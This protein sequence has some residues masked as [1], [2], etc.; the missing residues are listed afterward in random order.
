MSAD[1]DAF[2]RWEA[3]QKLAAEIL[4]EGGK[5]D[6]DYLAALEAV[7]AK[8]NDDPAFAAQMVMP[9]AENEIAAMRMPA[10]PDAIHAA[11]TAMI[12]ATASSVPTPWPRDGA[13]CA[14]P[15]CVIS[16]PP[17]MKPPPAWPIPTI[18]RPPT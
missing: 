9:P 13:A 4:L 10:D 12:R 3:G 8:A 2:N 6:R 18:A 14:M 7:L 17:T 16:P 5:A 11:R 1:S 15:R